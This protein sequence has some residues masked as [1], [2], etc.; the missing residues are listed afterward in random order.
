M[1]AARD[2]DPSTSTVEDG[3][4]ARRER[5]IVAL[6]ALAAGVAV[7]AAT[8]RWGVGMASDS[9]GYIWIS[10]RLRGGAGWSAFPTVWPPLYPSVLAIGSL[11]PGQSAADIARWTS[12]ASAMVMVLLAGVAVRETIRLPSLRYC[13]VVLVAAA[14]ALLAQQAYALTDAPAAAV[15]LAGL[16]VLGRFVRRPSALALGAL[17]VLTWVAFG[18][19]YQGLYLVPTGVVAMFALPR[20][21]SWRNRLGWAL[22]F[23]AGS[24]VILA[25][26]A[27]RNH[28]VDGTLLG[29]RA[30]AD[31]GI[32]R[33]SM[34]TAA[35]IG[36]AIS[37]YEPLPTIAAASLAAIVIAVF[38]IA[39][40]WRYRRNDATTTTDAHLRG[41]DEVLWVFAIYCAIHLLLTAVTRSIAAFDRID[42]RLIAAVVAP[43]FILGVAILDRVRTSLTSPVSKRL[44]TAMTV[45]GT[46]LMV[47]LGCRT[48]WLTHRDGG[49]FD[50]RDYEAVRTDPALQAIPTDC[51]VYANVVAPLY[52]AGRTGDAS[53]DRLGYGSR[54]ETDDLA[55]FVDEAHRGPVCL[56][57]I[58]RAWTQGSAYRPEELQAVVPMTRVAAGPEVSVYRSQ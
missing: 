12:A 34:D 16:V 19:R 50:G 22:A 28:A 2:D 39:A 46:A 10:D 47:L 45:G 1:V 24:L 14:P 42:V 13:A 54:S 11:L 21:W 58:D 38:A 36:R 23:V 41:G 29:P 5:V 8:Q 32:R 9:V 3:N 31:E 52:R 15:V 57:W 40:A 37:G 53:P 55:R 35:A 48:L 25:A 27:L 56:V 6:I 26:W 44:L 43:M 4:A 49:Q 17:C 20:A 7:V 51:H 30:A 18:L 33:N